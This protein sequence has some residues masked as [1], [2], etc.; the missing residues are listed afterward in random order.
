MTCDCCSHIWTNGVR[1]N[2]G[3]AVAH[4]VTRAGNHQR[5]C[6]SCFNIWLDN[7]DDDDALEPS[8]IRWIAA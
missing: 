2:H 8:L 7:A 4:W 3:P 1:Q 5:L 6:L